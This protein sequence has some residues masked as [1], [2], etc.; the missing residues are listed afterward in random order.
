MDIAEGW[1]YVALRAVKNWVLAATRL[2]TSN[3]GRKKKKQRPQNILHNRHPLEWTVQCD[4][5]HKDRSRAGYQTDNARS[6]GF[7]PIRFHLSLFRDRASSECGR[8]LEAAPGPAAG[9]NGFAGRGEEDGEVVDILSVG[10]LASIYGDD[11]PSN[12]FPFV[13]SNPITPDL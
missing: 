1:N 3:Y 5:F 8:Q 13:S 11:E 9:D 6:T 10:C 7:R 4:N 2:G 12:Q